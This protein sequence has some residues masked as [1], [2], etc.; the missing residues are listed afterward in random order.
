MGINQTTL[1]QRARELLGNIWTSVLL[2]I[3]LPRGNALNTQSEIPLLEKTDTGRGV[4]YRM[5]RI[6]I[7][8]LP[9]GGGG[10]GGGKA[11][12]SGGASWSGTGYI[13]DVSVLTYTFNGTDI[14]TA[15]PSTQTLAASD[16]TNGRFDAIV[17]NEAGV[18]SVLQGSA[19]PNPLTP[20]VPEDQLLVQYI[21]VEANTTQPVGGVENVYLNNNEWTMTTYALSSPVVGSVDFESENNPYEGVYCIQ[22]S[23]AGRNTG[24]RAQ[25]TGSIDTNDYAVLS[26]MF[27]IDDPL[28]S[29]RSL[30]MSVWNG[31]SSVGSVVNAMTQGGL[32]RTTVGVWQLCVIPLP[33][34]GATSIDRIH[35]RMDGGAA[36]SGV[37]WKLDYIRLLAGIAPPSI[38]P[39]IDVYEEQAFVGTRGKLNFTGNVALSEDTLNEWITI[40]I[41]PNGGNKYQTVVANGA[42]TTVNLDLG[43]I[44]F[45][46]VITDTEIKLTGD[47][48]VNIKYT[49]VFSTAFPTKTVTF[50]TSDFKGVHGTV[51]PIVLDTNAY[52]LKFPIID[53]L[54]TGINSYVTERSR[55]TALIPGDDISELNNDAGYV[56][57]EDVKGTSR[58]Y[59]KG[60]ASGIV[61]LTIV[62][63]ETDIDLDSGNRFTLSL[64]GNTELQVPLNARGQSL[65]ILVTNTGGYTLTF[66][67]DYIVLGDDPSTTMGDRILLNISCFGAD[68]PWVVVN[69]EP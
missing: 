57:E 65:A 44:I 33:L 21:Y 13:Y 30:L 66:H 32:S 6:P 25:R 45:V 67:S 53:F 40:H 12:I 68:N 9:S 10:G 55:N 64:T 3:E 59:T 11:L 1:R 58:E 35:F 62:A 52:E 20:S 41:D 38:Q 29:D 27:W 14:L 69:N 39:T 31:G 18:I 24:I 36:V 50:D 48:D 17:V 4:K 28:P 26:F 7:S 46:N 47:I 37:S 15:G 60:Q 22:V 54:G 23:S 56:T 19:T 16:P 61:A 2:F 5:T 49:F 34:F 51:N 8:A 63:G 42:S 43:N